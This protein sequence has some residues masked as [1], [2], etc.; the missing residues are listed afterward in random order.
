MRRDSGGAVFAAD[1]RVVS[2]QGSKRH[3]CFLQEQANLLISLAAGNLGSVLSFDKELSTVSN[4]IKKIKAQ[5][6][7]LK[8]QGAAS[9][10]AL[11]KIRKKLANL[12]LLAQGIVACRDGIISQSPGTDCSGAGVPE[13]SACDDLNPCTV[14]DKC[15]NLKC[16]GAALDTNPTINC[17]FD[18]CAQAIAQCVNAR[19]IVCLTGAAGDEICNEIDDDCNGEVDEKDICANPTAAPTATVAATNTPPAT[20]TAVNTSTPTATNTVIL[21]PTLTSTSTRTA[22][23]TRTSTATRT[24][25]RTP[26]ITPTTPCGIAN[27]NFNFN[28]SSCLCNGDDDCLGDCDVNG[29][30]NFCVGTGCPLSPNGLALSPQGCLCNLSADCYQGLCSVNPSSPDFH[31]CIPGGAGISPCYDTNN[32]ININFPGCRCTLGQSDDCSFGTNC[33]LIA[34]TTTAYCSG[35]GVVCGNPDNSTGSNPKFCPCNED[36][37]C[38]SFQCRASTSGNL[39]ECL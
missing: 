24:P 8:S 26:T 19:L 2:I 17:S 36:N 28:R 22:T 1:L 31:T 9:S 6:R 21:T 14:Q 25:T 39:P 30:I 5:L 3:G 34:N 15:Q 29:L 20:P 32:N 27:N 16:V 37:D 7:R 38:A 10:A 13:G 4:K 18:N 12:K 11:K 23:P 35:G 33:T